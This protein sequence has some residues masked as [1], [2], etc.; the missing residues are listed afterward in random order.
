MA[1]KD[2]AQKKLED[3]EDVFADIVNVLMFNGEKLVK[4]EELTPALPRSIYKFDGKMHEQ[5]RDTAKYW[6]KCE[7]HVAFIGFENQSAIDAD[8]PLRVLGYD[9]AAYRAQ[10]NAD[11]KDC[12]KQ[13]F[14]VVTL[15]LYFGIKE[16]WNKYRRLK[17]CFDVPPQLEP[18]VNDYKLNVIEVA[19][20]SDET[21]AKFTGDFKFFAEYLVQMRK[22][23]EYIPPSDEIK[24]VE[25]LLNLMRA[26]TGDDRF[27]KAV[28]VH[29]EKGVSNMKSFL[30]VA[31]EKGVAEGKIEGRIEGKAEGK[32]EG[33]VEG[34]AEGENRFAKLIELLLKDGKSEEVKEAAVDSVRRKELFALYGLE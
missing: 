28:E 4:P 15:V 24:H 31:F 20:L 21:L 10:L 29:R 7:L 12:P 2:A 27:E 18:F 6:N 26:V 16:R 11:K 5:E 30:T 8:M 33:K 3:H 13:R 22:T 14:P 19:W 1:E 32:A 23:G 17:E 25:E 9:G 34:K